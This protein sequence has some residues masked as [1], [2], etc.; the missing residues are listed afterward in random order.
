MLT[1]THTHTHTHTLLWRS[2]TVGP[3]SCCVFSPP[4]GQRLC[5]LLCHLSDRGATPSRASGHLQCIALSLTWNTQPTRLLSILGLALRE[6]P[7]QPLAMGPG[8]PAAPRTEPPLPPSRFLVPPPC[9]LGPELS[10]AVSACLSVLD[11]ARKGPTEAWGWTGRL[12][13]GWQ[14]TKASLVRPV[15]SSWAWLHLAGHSL[16]C[17]LQPGGRCSRRAGSC[18]PSLRLPLLECR[19]PKLV[20][21]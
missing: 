3:R 6:F 15:G 8:C 7:P 17:V 5:L 21:N 20:S 11:T 13:Q 4:W 18:L 1:H 14:G 16:P 12:W 10:P 19:E 9:S 2:P